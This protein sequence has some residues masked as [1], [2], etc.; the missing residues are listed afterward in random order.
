MY[1][2]ILEEGVDEKEEKEI[3]DEMLEKNFPPGATLVR[4]E[5][6]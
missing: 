1:A 3:I 6:R 4:W 5:Y 2:P